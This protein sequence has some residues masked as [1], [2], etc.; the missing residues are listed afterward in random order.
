MVGRLD[1]LV[2]DV[3]AGLQSTFVRGEPVLWKRPDSQ[4]VYVL[5]YCVVCVV[6]CCVCWCIVVYCVL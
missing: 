3:L 1:Q 6:V 5:L 2:E 4:Q